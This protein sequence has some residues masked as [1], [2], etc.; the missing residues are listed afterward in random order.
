MI[1]FIADVHAGNHRRF[2]G[3]VEAGINYRCHQVFDVLS[4]ARD[5]AKELHSPLVSLGD[6]F[7]SA[8][9]EPQIIAAAQRALSE[10]DCYAL[11]G[12]HEQVS[13]AF[14]DHSLGP[15]HGHGMI[16]VV[17]TPRV[18]HIGGVELLLVPFQPGKADDWLPSAVHHLNPRAVEVSKK[19]SLRVL[20]LHLGIRDEKTAAWLVD[21]HDAVSIDLLRGLAQTYGLDA[22]V[23][24]NWHERRSWKLELS[25]H[26]CE[27]MQVG[28]LVPTG[29]DNPGMRGYGTVATFDPKAK[30]GARLSYAELPGP[31]FLKL[32]AGDDVPLAKG[33]KLYVQITAPREHVAACEAH[34]A[35]S[36]DNG[37][38]VAGEV[39]PDGD[40]QQAA[41]RDAADS[42]RS[43]DTLAGALAAFVQRMP[44]EDEAKVDRSLVLA[45]CKGYL[46]AGGA[47]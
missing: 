43:E 45:K 18:E 38:F 30:E 36:I 31:R 44:L 17:E 46:A 1:S 8:R 21:S 14:G 20:C 11:L 34:L 22:I 2:G 15:L 24:G 28:A 10:V 41:V 9:I 5:R 6:L 7:D 27:V 3:K 13:T 35:A 19:D 25:D 4:A 23:A 47:E 29:F 37:D 33:N 32:R 16:E 12:N 40:E 42:A 39:V 26:Y